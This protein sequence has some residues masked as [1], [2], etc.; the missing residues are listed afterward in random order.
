MSWE[1]HVLGANSAVPTVDRYPSG[2]VLNIGKASI[3]FDCGEGSQLRML[4]QGVRKSRISSIL[5]SHMHG[6]HI[7]GLP[8]LLTSYNLY[9]RKSR[10]T[11]IGPQGI[12]SFV[13]YMISITSHEFNYPVDIVEITEEEPAIVLD[14]PGYRIKAFPLV[15]RVPTYGYKI[16]EK[17]KRIYLSKEKVRELALIDRDV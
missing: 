2:Q 12:R 11:I 15:H 3:L 5:I 16:E 6:E 9:G 1:L 4:E 13:D 14:D 7:F 8:G 17:I 10:L